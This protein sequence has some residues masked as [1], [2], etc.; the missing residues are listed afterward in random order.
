M[1]YSPRFKVYTADNEYVAA[2][3]HAEDAA[4]IVASYEGG[5]I[6]DGHRK[7]LW[8]EGSEETSSGDSYDC[9]ASTVHAR[10]LANRRG[11]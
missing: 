1:A 7:V 5:T 3:K 8:R 9:T 2:C 11:H 6:R 10:L 4:A